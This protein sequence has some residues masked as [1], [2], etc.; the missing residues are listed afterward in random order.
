MSDIV[1]ALSIRAGDTVVRDTATHNGTGQGDWRS[2]RPIHASG[3][4]R[5]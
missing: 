5:A 4:D 3:D 1:N 2:P